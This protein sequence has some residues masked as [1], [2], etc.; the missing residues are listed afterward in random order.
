[1]SEEEKVRDALFGAFRK[2]IPSGR[3]IAIKA[4]AEALSGRESD[5]GWIKEHFGNL[6]EEVQFGMAAPWRTRVSVV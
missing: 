4:V 6:V 1:M 2:K 5:V 3:S